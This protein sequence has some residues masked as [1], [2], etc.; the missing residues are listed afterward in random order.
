MMEYRKAVAKVATRWGSDCNHRKLLL[1]LF[2]VKCCNCS[3]SAI[4]T[5]GVRLY[6]SLSWL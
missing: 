1:L 4:D 2:K 5:E 3:H 6:W